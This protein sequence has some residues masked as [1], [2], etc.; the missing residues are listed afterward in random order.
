MFIEFAI[1]FNGSI[2]KLLNKLEF[3]SKNGFQRS[4]GERST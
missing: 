2:Q 1:D 3:S 4:T